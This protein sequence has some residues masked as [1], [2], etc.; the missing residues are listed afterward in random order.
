MRKPADPSW[1]IHEPTYFRA[2]VVL[3]GWA[4][5]Y[6]EKMQLLKSSRYSLLDID[7]VYVVVNEIA[8][9]LNKCV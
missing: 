5:F 4:M 3:S 8:P 1:K 2:R 6:A 7:Y 9:S